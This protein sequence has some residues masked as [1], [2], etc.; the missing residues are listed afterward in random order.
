[1]DPTHVHVAPI[2]ARPQ[3]SPAGLAVPPAGASAVELATVPKA[4]S[5][6]R[7]ILI[8]VGAIT[9]LALLGL[10]LLTAY[11]LGGFLNSLIILT[12]VLL[13]IAL[14]RPLVTRVAEHRRM[15]QGPTHGA[16]VHPE[17]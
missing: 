11:T 6:A 10:G 5:K 16:P 7:A 2:E 13:L 3:P 12:A 1:M 9:F 14:L 8:G 17:R 4:P 15:P